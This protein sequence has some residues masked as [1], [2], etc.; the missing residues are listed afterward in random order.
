[1]TKDLQQIKNILKGNLVPVIQHFKKEMKEYAE[2]M[3]F[4]KAEIIRKKIE[5]LENYQARSVIVSKHVDQCRCVFYF[6][7]WR[8][9]LCELP[10]GTEWHHC[11]NAYHYSWKRS[12]MKLMKK[13][14]LLPLPNCE[15]LSTVMQKKS[16]FRFDIEYPEEGVTSNRSQRRR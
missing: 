2:N 9:C 12:W 4:E 10:D 6:K 3:E 1:M 13:F 7:R 8:Y 14:C 5:H 11:S 16:L 15:P